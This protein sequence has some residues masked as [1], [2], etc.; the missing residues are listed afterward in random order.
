[1]NASPYC[2]KYLLLMNMTGTIVKNLSP[3]LLLCIH[4]AA[5]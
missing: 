2:M 3:I 5:Y 4:I 1:M